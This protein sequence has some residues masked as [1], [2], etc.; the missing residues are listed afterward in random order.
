M[1]DGRSENRKC[2][3]TPIFAKADIFYRSRAS[4]RE[5]L[6]STHCRQSS[7]DGTMSVVQRKEQFGDIRK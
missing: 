5:R 4:I 1:S 3:L 2:S 7:L 6:F